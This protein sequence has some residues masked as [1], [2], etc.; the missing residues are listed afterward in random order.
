M[1]AHQPSL[2][3]LEMPW[4]IV[5][6]SESEQYKSLVPPEAARL[7]RLLLPPKLAVLAGFSAFRRVQSAIE[8]GLTPGISLH[9][10]LRKCFFED[11]MRR[12]YAEGVRQLVVIGAGYDSLALRLAREWPDLQAI[13]VDHPA[14][15]AAK[16]QR[17]AQES[18]PPNLAFVAADLAHEGLAD[19]LG[20]LGAFDPAR[21]TAFIAEGLLM[22]LPEAAVVRLFH[23]IRSLAVG[24]A[25]FLFSYMTPRL[26]TKGGGLLGKRTILWMMRLIGEPLGW[27]VLPTDLAKFVRARDFRLVD[28]ADTAELRR[29]YFAGKSETGDEGIAEELFAVAD[30]LP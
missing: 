22:Y 7:A 1:R 11:Q 10:A 13:E 5:L 29:R 6:C 17:L 4:A 9:L 27:T 19:V 2:T 18:L 24:K 26:V 14:T 15:Q 8:R 28:N 3:A 21:A 16:R 30:S 25:R 20:R 12:A 23:G